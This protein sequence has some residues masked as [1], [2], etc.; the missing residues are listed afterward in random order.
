MKRV[1]FLLLFF[2]TFL[3][4]Q[5]MQVTVNSQFP[6]PYLS[7]WMSVP[8]LIQVT[9]LNTNPTTETYYIKIRLESDNHGLIMEGKTESFTVLGGGT[10]TIDNTHLIDINSSTINDALVDQV[11]STNQ[12]PEGAYTLTLELYRQGA[13]EPVYGPEV[14]T[15]YVLSFDRIQILAPSDGETVFNES[16]LIF[17]WTSV[18]EGLSDFS[19]RYHLALFEIRPGQIPYRVI[20]SSYPV[21][22]EDV[23]NNTQLLYPASAYG[24]LERGKKYIWY[25]Q[26]FNNNPGPNFNQPLGE[27][28]GRSEIVSFYYQEKTEEAVE[29]ADIRRLELVPGVAY[30]KNLSAVSKTETASD[31]ILDGSATLVAYVQ[32]DSFEVPVSVNHLTFLKGSMF[33]PSFTGGDVSASLSAEMGHLPG[34][35]ELPIEVT[36]LTFTPA[37]GLTFGAQF[38]VPG[39][40]YVRAVDLSGRLQ[41]SSAGFTGQLDYS[42]DWDHPIVQF[43]HELFKM[44]LTAL[45]IDLASFSVR[46]DAAVRFLSSDSAWRFPNVQWTL[47]RLSFPINISGQQLLSLIPDNDFLKLKIRT[48]SGSVSFDTETGDFDFDLGL[49][50]NLL[51]PFVAQPQTLPEISLRLSKAHGLQLQSFKPHLSRD[52]LLNLDWMKLAPRNL[53]LNDFSYANGRYTFDLSLDAEFN[54]MN[55]PQFNSPVIQGIHIT[56]QGITLDAQDFSNLSLPP[57]EL[58]GL[59][60]ELKRFHVGAMQFNWQ[61]ASFP[62]WDFSVNVDVRLP[63]L[64]LNFASDLREQVFHL[65]DLHLGGP[66]IHYEF[67]Q[68]TFSGNQGEIPLG[69]GAAFY[70]TT[71]GGVLDLAWQNHSV[72]NQSTLTMSGNLKLPDWFGCNETQSLASSQLRLDGFGHISGQIENF[73]PSCPLKFGFLT[74]QVSNSSLQFEYS[75]STQKA[76]LDAAVTATLPGIAAGTESRANGNITIDLLSGK[77]LQGRLTFSDFSLNIPDANP[78]LTFHISSATLTKDGLEINGT[79]QLALAG[80]QVGVVFDHLLLDLR[81]FKVISGHAYFNSSFAFKLGITDGSLSWR[82]VQA[83]QALLEENNLMLNLPSNLHITADGLQM[84]GT[85]AVALNFGGQQFDSL[86]ARFSDDFTLQFKPFKVKNGSVEFLYGGNRIAYL[87]AGGIHFDLGYFGEQALPAQLPLPNESIA[88]LVLKQ[89]GQSLVDIQTVANGVRI[90]TRAG[91]P[92]R[93]VLPGLQFGQPQPP[94]VGVEFSIV[95]DPLHFQLHEGHI[96]ANI[97]QDT[98]G[99]DLSKVGLPLEI[100]NLD[101]RKLSGVK[102]FTFKG[103]PALFGSHLSES[104]SLTLTIDESGQLSSNFD[105]TL[106]RTVPLLGQSDLLQL[107]VNR[108][109]GNVQCSLHNLNFNITASGGLK[110]KMNDVL[111]DVVSL[112]LNI[113]P[114]GFSTQNVTVNPQLGNYA[115]NLG[116]IDMALSDF[117]I[118]SLSYDPNGGWDFQFDFSAKLGFPQFGS[119]RLPKIEHITIG[120]NGIHFPQTTLPDL[121]LPSFSLGGFQLALTNV[122]IPEVTVDIFHGHFDFGSASDLRADFELNMPDIAA[123]LSPQLANLGLQVSDCS[124]RNGIIT[125]TIQNRPVADPGIEIPIGGGAKFFAKTFR[126]SL[127]ADS[128]SGT[129]KQ[130]FDVLVEGAFQL[131]QGLFPCAAPQNIATALHINSEGR[132]SGTIANFVPSCPMQFGPLRL[133]VNSSNLTFDFSSGE[134]SAILAM[135]AQAKLPAPTAGDSVTARGNITFDLAKG[136]FIDGQ[137]AIQTPF[138]LNLPADGNFL[139][140]TINSA[141]LN[142]DGLTI[143]GGNQLN[144]GGGMTVAANFQNF[145]V[146]LHPFKVKSGKVTFSSSFAFKIQPGDGGLQWQAVSA[147]PTIDTDFGIALNLPDTLGLD[148]GQFYAQGTAQVDFKY[149]GQSYSGLTAR[150]SDGFKMDIWPVRVRHGKV[151][152]IREGETL[153]Y[154]DSTGFVPG[155]VLG[156]LP[157]P[158]SIPLPSASVAYMKL[159]DDQGHLLVETTDNGSAYMLQIKSGKSLK[160]KIPALA[161]NG[162]VP[163]IEVTS[164]SVGVNKSTY[165]IVSGGIRVEAPANGV[166]LDLQ[167]WGIP[168]D[169]TR[170]QFKKINGSYGV[171]LGARLKLPE[172][173]ADLNLTVDSLLLSASGIEGSVSS[174]DFHEHYTQNTHYIKEIQLGSDAPV[175]LKVEGIQ[176]HFASGTFQIQFSGDLFAELFQEND[177]PAPLHFTASVGTDSTAFNMDIAHLTQGIPLKIARMLPLANNAQL[178]PLK[179]NTAG[180]DFELEVNTLLKIP[181]FGDDFGVEV[182]GLKISKNHGLHLPQITLN[183]PA[184][185][186]HFE[187]FSMTFDVNDVGF[188]YEPKNGKKVFGVELGGQIKFMDNTSSFS[189]LKIGSDGSFSI[190]QASLISRPIEIIPQ[191]LSLETMEF[192]ND[193]LQ[194]SFKVTPPQPLNQTPSTIRFMIS[195]DGHVSGGGQVVLLDEQHG[196]GHGD[197]TEWAFWQGSVDLVYMDMDLNLEHLPDSK[198]RINGDV[199]LNNE[200]P[201]SDYVQI[202]YKQGGQ[203]FPGLQLTFGG[204]IQYGNFRLQGHPRFDLDVVGFTLNNLTSVPG[205]EFGL[206]IS[207]DVNLNIASASSTVRFENLRIGKDGSMSNIGSSITGGSITIGSVFSFGIQSFKYEKNGGDIEY[208]SGSMPSESNSGSQTTQ[209]VHADSYVEFGVTMS[210]GESFSGGV[211]RFLLFTV[212]NSPNIIIDNLH[213]SIQ[214]VVTASFDMQYLSVQ[215][216]M[217]FLAA[218]QV[219]VQPNI[220]LTTVGLFENIN[221]KLRFGIFAT[222]ELPGP[223]IVLFP[224]IS[225][226]RLGGGFFYNPKQEYLDLVVSKTDLKDNQILDNLPKLNNGEAKFAAMLYAGVVIMDKTMVSGST[227]ITI[228]DQYINFAGKVLLLNMKDRLYGGFVMTARF[229][230][231]YID[232]LIF[233]EAKF[234]LV[235]G[236]GQLQFKIAEDQW[237][238]KGKMDATVV[239]PKF[240]KANA[241]FFIGNPGFMFQASARSGFDFW[242]VTVNSTVSGTIWMR[243]QGPREFG[244]YFSYLAE[245]EV[246]YGLASI[247]A[248]VRAILLVSDHYDVYG[249]ASGSVCVCW[250]AKC[251]DGSIW[252]KVSDRSPHFDGGFGSDPEMR[253]KINEAENMADNMENEAQ[254]AQNDMERKLVESTVLN[255]T[256]IKQAGINL[257]AGDPTQ[258]A[259]SWKAMEISNGGLHSNERSV[260]QDFISEYLTLPSSLRATT[261]DLSVLLAQEKTALN[262]AEAIAQSVGQQLNVRLGDL[263]PVDEMREEYDMDSPIIAFSDSVAVTTY[264]DADGKMHQRFTVEPEL[265]IDQEKVNAHKNRAQRM[266]ETRQRILEQIYARILALNSYLNRIDGILNASR[267]QNTVAALGQ[268]YMEAHQKLEKFFWKNH[269]YIYTL[270][271]WASGRI[272]RLSAQ[273]TIL[274]SFVVNKANRLSDMDALK[275]LAKARARRLAD[276]TFPGSADKANGLYQN[277]EANIDQITELENMREIARNLG[278]NLWVD[279]PASGITMLAAQFDSAVVANINS[280]NQQ[281]GALELR[282][283]QITQVIDRIYDM[284]VAYAQA[285]YD[286]CDRY[287]YWQ[288]GKAPEDQVVV[289]E[290]DAQGMN[291]VS[292]INA[293]LLPGYAQSVSGMNLVAGAGLNGL[294]NMQIINQHLPQ[295]GQFSAAKGVMDIGQF[296]TPRP[297]VTVRVTPEFFTKIFPDVQALHDRLA[298]QLTSPKIDHITVSTYKDKHTAHIY[299]TYKADHPAGIA[300]YSFALAPAYQ[301]AAPPANQG[302]NGN[303]G[304]NLNLGGN[305]FQMFNYAQMIYSGMLTNTGV[306]SNNYKMIGKMEDFYS[307]FIPQNVNEMHKEYALKIRA[308]STSGFVNRR[309]ANFSV[310]YDGQVNNIYMDDYGMMDDHTPPTVQKIEVPAYQFATDRIMKI[311][312]EAV[313][314]E[315]DVMELAYS[316]SDKPTI[317]DPSKVTWHGIGARTDFNI[318]GLTLR[319]NQRYYVYIKAK[320]SVGIWSRAYVS[321][322]I[323]I[324]TTAPGRVQITRTNRYPTWQ[325]EPFNYENSITDYNSGN[326]VQYEGRN[327]TY[328]FVIPAQNAV[329]NASLQPNTLF[330]VVGNFLNTPTLSPDDTI[331]PGIRVEFSPATDPESGIEQYVFKVTRSAS[332]MNPGSGWRLL[333]VDNGGRPLTTLKLIGQPLAYMDSFYVHIRA[334]NRAGVLGPKVTV[335]PIRPADPTAPT[336]PEITYGANPANEPFYVTSLNSIILGLE[337]AKDNETGIVGYEYKIGTLPGQSDIRGWTRDGVRVFSS[338]ME[339]GLRNFPDD[340]FREPGVLYGNFNLAPGWL[341][342]SPRIELKNLSLT[343]G[344]SIYVTIRAINGDGVRGPEAHSK[345]IKVDVTPPN[346]PVVSMNFDQQQHTIRLDIGN[347]G[348]TETHLYGFKVAVRKNGDPQTTQTVKKVFAVQESYQSGASIVL[349]GNYFSQDDVTIKVIGVNRANLRSPVTTIRHISIS[350]LVGNGVTSGATLNN[351]GVLNMG[352]FSSGSLSNLGNNNPPPPPPPPPPPINPT[353]GH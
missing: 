101:Y 314:A 344:A 13:Q 276:I 313:D 109:Q 280:R 53:A 95:V 292:Y 167:N 269:Q 272:A 293:H 203:V 118:P 220:S 80:S 308:R 172:S 324:D 270:H 134:Q 327:G 78:I 120:K 298:Q 246:L 288:L 198:V 129:P 351:S 254:K 178:P 328:S 20:T 45:H 151:S 263:P 200:Q 146:G 21:F 27:N 216:G 309:L 170:F 158:D 148:N 199:W 289:T 149:N 156:A 92:V 329:Q 331:P 168:V 38:K 243:Y 112:D 194:A 31:Y 252:I 345:R 68:K 60:F 44:H 258:T 277:L 138:R 201:T 271:N 224:G 155:N 14:E 248:N 238:I 260:I 152:F 315:S 229:D 23:V 49:N 301:I 320:N 237:Y 332:D 69:A 47:P 349:P 160:I 32:S 244:A 122:R 278:F 165:N 75:D 90:A 79:Q 131:P 30:L 102:T 10:Y 234:G 245:A 139:T 34:L 107:Q 233:A 150:F 41:L 63:H 184:D 230:Q 142:R 350:S 251:W 195:P 274:R 33:P 295:G 85:S 250:G 154:I 39:N 343:Q 256:Q 259:N 192:K 190:A 340:L 106:N 115:F 336:K 222:A 96:K 185:F 180:N 93:L 88:Y 261:H 173:L 119:F 221:G 205:N 217:R 162:T 333:G 24:R 86:A 42:G 286:L 267:G 123:G 352:N 348:D 99:F 175:Q 253:E 193:S 67:P 183:N 208:S 353:G 48:L 15:F 290:N 59:S 218:G 347:A 171:L 211:D 73:A 133:T 187:L 116:L 36:E 182:K 342:G 306:Y 163:E 110:M 6:S 114:H 108:V 117:T 159:R 19:V 337:P 3:F 43:D 207:G 268:K 176:A 326:T 11:R 319:H 214:D 325:S 300:N 147:N 239:N 189:G 202:G 83:G 111:Q 197:Q 341:P 322:A 264:V 317:S 54:V 28:E 37:Q 153:A 247:N 127:F 141:V 279:V 164:L 35:E 228:T 307:Y 312:V 310:R 46:T 137:I 191:Q 87:D 65:N 55:L 338:S 227:M 204:D 140:F 285:L 262:A 266:E 66:Q 304:L 241:N 235:E 57:F 105:L 8:N 70:V 305:N 212:D 76:L 255:E 321:R 135:D 287:L 249:E 94:E 265:Q 74:L 226:A 299:A 64:P 166:L 157:I 5:T 2:S 210:I 242:I 223:G 297:A 72:V 186:L 7:D 113:T 209:T 323:K 275:A 283:E 71:L 58:A 121:D 143:S 82:A 16:S 61:D 91:Q 284:R 291:L 51:F 282:Q 104:D 318:L 213:L 52:M 281:V 181:Q 219:V 296:T 136:D 215:G 316:V 128:T 145:V 18:V 1:L 303:G 50:A 26:A 294:Q 77:M 125:G 126:G 12:I 97:P 62:N 84:S 9:V 130:K 334:M 169:L 56:R 25:V 273:K 206:D 232:G 231:F 225:L 236:K 302:G 81:H 257:F 98:P 188:F 40:Q 177:Q 346:S 124:F 144:L 17:Q 89:G 161:K 339:I 311:H 196:L 100:K 174:G 179:I 4:S 132:L 240:L 103:L 330:P 335:G 22:E 29:L